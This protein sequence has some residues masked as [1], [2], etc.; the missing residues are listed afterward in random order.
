MHKSV[1]QQVE[2]LLADMQRERQE[3]QEVPEPEPAR[4]PVSHPSDEGEEA[5]E[6]VLH[7]YVLTDEQAQQLELEA[8]CVEAQPPTPAPQQEAD[9]QLESTGR[10][11]VNI[12]LALALVL[13]LTLGVLNLLI[14]LPI[15]LASATVTI[16]PTSRQIATTRTVTI[17]SSNANAV[18]QQVP[19]RLLDTITLTQAKT[20]A[21]TGTGHQQAQA[22]HGF[23]TFYNALPVPQTMPAGELLTGANGVE[24]VTVQNAVIPAGTLTTNGQVTVPAQAV[25]VGPQGNIRAGDIY[26]KCCRDNVFVSNGPF[27]GG[28]DARSYQMVTRQDISSAASSLKT[29]LD[30]SVLAALKQQVQPDESLI[31]PVP[32]SATVTPDHQVG[33]ETTQVKVVVSETC[34]GEVYTT[35]ALHDLLMQTMIQQAIKQVGNGYSLIGDLQTSITRATMNTRQETMI[36]QVKVISTWMYQFSQMQQDKIKLAIRG[37]SKEEA[38]ALLLHMPGI[39]TVSIRISNS[40]ALPTDV[41]H[42]HLHVV[43]RL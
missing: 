27:H 16:I 32:C 43:I 31:T 39:Q 9:H 6:H 15:M 11:D 36:L 34:T 23:I 2:E 10:R 30:Q 4:D 33:S 41:Q 3:Q 40:N 5:V 7:L 1:H 42:I 37:K 35:S 38:T 13:C 26:G 29:S 18:H 12:L 8:N 25:N 20:V 19:G 28:Q 14:Y 22:A 24:V 21:A 17:V